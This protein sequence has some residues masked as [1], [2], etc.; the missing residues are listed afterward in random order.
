[1]T[2]LHSFSF[3]WFT[4]HIPQFQRHLSHLR[5]TP[6]LAVEVGAHEGRSTTWLLDNVLT[7]EGARIVSIDWVLQP[8]FWSNIEASHGLEKTQFILGLSG[9]VLR[10]LPLGTAD[11]VY[12]DGSHRTPDVLEDAVL[13]FRLL[14]R[15]GIMAFDDYHWND[16]RFEHEGFPKPAIDCFLNAYKLRIQ[17]LEKTYQVWIRRTK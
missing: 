16:P 9:E 10:T 11:F 1:M 7:H 17:V 5:D 4:A 8:A 3:D 14:K 12:I 13:A 6:C 2:G 15:D